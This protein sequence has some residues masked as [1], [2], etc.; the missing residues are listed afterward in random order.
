MSWFWSWYPVIHYRTSLAGIA[1]FLSYVAEVDPT[2]WRMWCKA[3]SILLLGLCAS[4]G[5][6]AATIPPPS[7]PVVLAAKEASP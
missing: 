4:D 6:L 2:S 7:S 5:A 3:I 1:G